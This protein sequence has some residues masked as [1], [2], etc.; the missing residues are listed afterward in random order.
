M[1]LENV[2]VGEAYT[3]K[4]GKNLVAVRRMERA[5]G[6]EFARLPRTDRSAAQGL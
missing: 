3:L 4:V 5:R 2:K 6:L 1:K